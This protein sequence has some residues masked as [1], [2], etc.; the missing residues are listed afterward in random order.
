MRDPMKSLL[1]VCPSVC[2]SVSSAFF[3]GITDYF[4]LIFDTMLD[5][6]SILKLTELFLPG[7]LIFA[8]IWVKRAKNV[9]KIEFL[10]FWKTFV[11]SFSWK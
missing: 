7:K 8:Q 5:N 10:H 11:I 2:P 4:F 9:P 1:S 3:S 6:W